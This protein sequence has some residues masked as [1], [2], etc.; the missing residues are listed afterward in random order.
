MDKNKFRF[1]ASG[2]AVFYIGADPFTFY[3]ARDTGADNDA[4]A[5]IIARK[6]SDHGTDHLTRT[7]NI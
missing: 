3:P 2:S 7:D 1:Y 5:Y 4:A 6:Y